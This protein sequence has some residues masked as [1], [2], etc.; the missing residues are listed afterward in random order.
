[1]ANVTLIIRE[2]RISGVTVYRPE[3]LMPLYQE[4][5]GRTV[6]LTV[7][8]EIAKRITDKYGADGYVLSRALIDSQ[9]LDPTGAIVRLHVVE[10]YVDRV[11]WPPVL[12]HYRDFFSEYAAKIMAERPA[13]LFTIERYLLLAGDLPGLRFRNRLVP[14]RTHPGAATLI[15]EVTEKPIDAFVRA[16]NLGTRARGPLQYMASTKFN[17][18]LGT[19]EAL[20]VT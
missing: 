1:A 5:I 8:Y 3:Q 15:V 17:N 4:F 19:H 9:Q 14:S 13:N 6:P 7:V 2:I 12:A 18:L 20:T 10:G 16:D 11:E